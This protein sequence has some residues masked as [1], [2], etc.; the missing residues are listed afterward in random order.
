MILTTSENGGPFGT[1][2]ISTHYQME[3]TGLEP[4]TPCLQSIFEEGECVQ[5]ARSRDRDAHISVHRHPNACIL[6]G[7]AS[8][9]V[10]TLGPIQYRC[11]DHRRS[12]RRRPGH[13]WEPIDTY[14]EEFQHRLWR[15]D[16]VGARD[17]LRCPGP[18][19]CQNTIEVVF[20]VLC[21][22]M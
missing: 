12:G 5:P 14:Y 9:D 15:P 8:T 21:H 2:I 18:V 7:N 16:A 4:V 1:A 11:V 10:T 6:R 17:A 22:E 3:R 19:A 13:D 20:E